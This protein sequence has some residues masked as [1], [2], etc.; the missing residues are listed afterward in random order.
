MAVSIGALGEMIRLDGLVDPNPQ[1]RGAVGRLAHNQRCKIRVD[2]GLNTFGAFAA[3]VQSAYRRRLADTFNAIRGF[4][5]DQHNGL[6]LH[7]CDR[8]FVRSDGGDIENMGADFYYGGL[9]RGSAL[10]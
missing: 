5:P 4:D 9:H 7:R 3:I 8:H 1:R 10:H 6:A 2:I